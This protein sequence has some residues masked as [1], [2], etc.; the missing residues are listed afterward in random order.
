M[1]TTSSKTT[2]SNEE[3]HNPIFLSDVPNTPVTVQHT[4]L[5][6][7]VNQQ[8]VFGNEIENLSVYIIDTLFELLLCSTIKTILYL[9]INSKKLLNTLY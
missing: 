2:P 5:P 3:A 8:R 6:S 7:G 1:S 4:Q 9:F